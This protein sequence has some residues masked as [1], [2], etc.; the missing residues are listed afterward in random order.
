ML[1]KIVTSNYFEFIFLGISELVLAALLKHDQRLE[2]TDISVVMAFW[3]V[4]AHLFVKWLKFEHEFKEL[5]ESKSQTEKLLNEF[6]ESN[7]LMVRISNSIRSD[8]EFDNNVKL[9]NEHKPFHLFL[10]ALKYEYY[11]SS[12]FKYSQ[13]GNSPAITK[14]PR[15]YFEDYRKQNGEKHSIWMWLIEKSKSYQSIQV[16]NNDTSEIYLSNIE[17]LTTET[18]YLKTQYENPNSKLNSIM[19]L[20]VIKDEWISTD[21]I[22]IINT[23]VTKYLD[24]W[25]HKLSKMSEESKKNLRVNYMKISDAKGSFTNRECVED[26][27]IFDNILGVQTPVKTEGSLINDKLDISF[28]FEEQYVNGYKTKFETIFKNATPLI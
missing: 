5:K 22:E 9:K 15:F 11:L 21:G 27:G 8:L 28:Y 12:Y 24:V 25:K 13:D 20:F 7:H 16:L 26:I 14:I 3:L 4:I 10:S 17:R 2:L 1:K 19:K 18:N 6:A 23:E